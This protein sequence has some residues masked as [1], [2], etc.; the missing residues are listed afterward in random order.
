MERRSIARARTYLGARVAF[1]DRYSTMDCLVRN[2][3]PAGAKLEVSGGVTL[4][5]E[6]D[7]TITK[8]AETLRAR[9]LWR[10]GDEAG[11]AFL[12]HHP[13]S[14]VVPLDL[15]RRLRAH[16]AEKAALLRRIRELSSGE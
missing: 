12:H 4:P 16:E 13:G 9:I 15:A 5:D 1:N 7:L 14:T 8:R 6:V 2:M 3:S 11:L 10:R